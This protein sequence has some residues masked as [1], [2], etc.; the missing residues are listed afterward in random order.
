MK[1]LLAMILGAAALAL[2][3]VSRDALLNYGKSGIDTATNVYIDETV[4]TIYNNVIA[5]AQ[6]GTFVDSYSYKMNPSNE[7]IYH[8]K[9]NYWEKIIEKL[10]TLFPDC[11][12]ADN[13]FG[14]I[15]VYWGQ[16]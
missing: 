4:T 3:P 10:Q 13:K 14:G 9:V 1:L 8:A 11:V 5:T 2:E 12:V 16:T 7:L 15:S 6:R